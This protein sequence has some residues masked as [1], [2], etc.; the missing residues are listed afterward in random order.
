V[1]DGAVLSGPDWQLDLGGVA[2]GAFVN[3]VLRGSRMMRLDLWQGDTRRSISCTVG[4]QGWRTDQGARAFLTLARD[5]LDAMA[6]D[7][8]IT[9]GERGRSRLVMFAIGVVALVTGLGLLAA[10]VASGVSAE[11]LAAAA[12]PVLGLAAIGG[13]MS[14]AYAPWKRPP[15]ATPA[16]LA[17]VLGGII[18]DLPAAP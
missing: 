14:F 17:K 1:L 10:A 16:A 3:H 7:A 8:T 4:A 15:Q 13:V 6:P 9:L 11:R 18:D 12:V 5:A 2:Q